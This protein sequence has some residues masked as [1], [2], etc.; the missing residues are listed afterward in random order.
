MLQLPFFAELEKAENVLLAGA[1][2]GFD[3][4]CGLP[5]Y[6][7]LKNAG[8]EVHLA[9]LSFSDINGAQARRI[10][11]VCAAITAD[12]LGNENYFPEL[13]LARWMRGR[14]EEITIY[15]FQRTGVRPLREAYE[16]LARELGFDTLILV[17]GGTDSLMRGDE[18]GLGTPVEDIASILAANALDAQRKMLVCLGFGVDAFHGVCHAHFLEAVAD[19]TQRGGFLGMW[20][21]TQEMPEVEFYRQA[22]EFV[23]RKMPRYPSIVSSSILSAIE[24][25]FG[26]YHTTSRTQNSKLFINPLMALY[27]CF[28]LEPV[29]A[30]LLYP[31]AIEETYNEYEI[32]AIIA[33]LRNRTN[34]KPYENMPM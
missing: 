17:D 14:G 7:A 11:P 21:L 1:G 29:A 24:G 16:I 12:S 23:F 2:G 34:R 4:F 8:K 13:H 3:I 26:D 19:V 30:R 33:D 25:R 27:W 20:S 15:S 31:K 10:S 18:S 28:Q 5:L 32:S 22:S 6:A 9:N